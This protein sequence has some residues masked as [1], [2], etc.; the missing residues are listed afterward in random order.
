[1]ITK[2]D[3]RND[4]VE[5]ISGKTQITARYS[6]NCITVS[7]FPDYPKTEQQLS[8][9]LKI[10]GQNTVTI[11]DLRD[12]GVSTTKSG[13]G[14]L[15]FNIGIQ[16]LHLYFG[17]LKTPSIAN[18]INILGKASPQS[19]LKLS[20]KEKIL[21]IQYREKFWEDS[22]LKYVEPNNPHSEIKATLDSLNIRKEGLCGNGCSKFID[23]NCFWSKLRKPTFFSDD[24]AS[25]HKTQLNTDKILSADELIS[26]DKQETL[27]MLKAKRISQL[28]T[29]LIMLIILTSNSEYLFTSTFLI[30]ALALYF[31]SVYLLSMKVVDFISDYKDSKERKAEHSQ[32]LAELKKTIETVEESNNGLI[33][34][35]HH[36][37]IIRDPKLDTETNKRLVK[38]SKEQFFLSISN[39]YV[40]YVEYI[41]K[42]KAILI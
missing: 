2:N 21:N 16:L 41:N 1:L 18:S 37:L 3:L 42:A 6:N 40:D 10:D 31:I 24:I 23:I 26:L 4:G 14:R 5:Y 25:L 35:L 22:G 34:R 29:I 8:L 9:F 15:I 28:T 36:E 39:Q 13:Y 32:G 12:E 19:D 30:L 33:W 38:Q 27:A 7:L 17:S 11:T 20:Q